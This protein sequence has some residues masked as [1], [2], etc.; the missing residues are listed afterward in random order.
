[1]LLTLF[2]F[3]LS[4]AVIYFACEFFVN[5]VE[6]VG[7]R[8]QLGATATGTV[9]AAFGTALPESA[10]TFMAVVFGETPEQ[11]DIGVGAAMG[12][13]LVLATLAYAVVGLALWRA[14]RGQPT[15]ANCINADQRRLARDQAWF[16]GIFVFKVGLGLLAFAWKPWLGILFLATY[17]LYVKRELSNDEDCLDC[18]DL[19]PL[20]LRPRDENPSMFW[21]A[22]QTLLALV[23]I[24][25][26]S[27]VFV[28]QIE[29]LGI[30]MGASPHVAALLLAPVATELP[31]IMN[32]LIWVRQ[33]KE[34]LALAN[35]SGAMMIQAT[36]PSALGIFMTPWLL[37]G[38]LLAAGLFTMLSISLLWLRFRRAGMSVP[39]LSAVGGFM[40]CSGPIWVGISTPDGARARGSGPRALL[41]KKQNLCRQALSISGNPRKILPLS[42]P[43][44]V[45]VNT[46][47]G[48]S[49]RSCIDAAV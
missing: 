29:L 45:F 36:I 11:K 18:E 3:F 1:M 4:A 42:I 49:S 44:A 28:N 33:G 20:K 12:G 13:P 10:V 46:D 26:A 37:D 23:V 6:W 39:A 34:R 48:E 9:L 5:G 15:Q 27:H 25:G 40:P 24:A 43:G 38:P 16:M 41:H 31:E 22:T 21:A 47:S 8:F 30:A 7:H 32:A 19:E 35:I 17:G 14:R 2:L